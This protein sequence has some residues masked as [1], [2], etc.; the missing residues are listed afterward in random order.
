MRFHEAGS[1]I[2]ITIRSKAAPGRSFPVNVTTFEQPW[3]L[4]VSGGM[5]MGLFKG[6]RT[7]SLSEDG[8]GGTQFAGGLKKRVESGS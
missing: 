4:K 8:S 1:R 6:V 2:E 7:Y 5:P 3:R